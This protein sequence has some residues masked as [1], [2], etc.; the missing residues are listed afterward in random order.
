LNG[1]KAEVQVIEM[2]RGCGIFWCSFTDESGVS[3]ISGGACGA[4]AALRA[5]SGF[6]SDANRT[7]PQGK[8]LF[9]L[10]N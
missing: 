6:P 5:P 8:S 1:I 10:E 2:A 9:K 4:A 7:G 3:G